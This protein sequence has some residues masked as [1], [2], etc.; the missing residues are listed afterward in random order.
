MR[1][2]VLRIEGNLNSNRYI[3]EVL[4]PQVLPLFR[5]HHMPYFSRTMPG[6]TWQGLCKP[7]KDD[8]YHCFPGL[9]VHQTCRPSNMSRIWFVGDL[10]VRVL[11]HA[12]WTRI[13]T[14]WRDIPQ[15]DIQGLFDSIPRRIET[16][17]SAWRLHTILKSHAHRLCTVL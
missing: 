14:A 13:Q 10:F 15:K 3:R 9:H 8:G 2:R 6:H 4:L 12:L 5:Q 11:Q 17:C 16:D 1:S 7:P